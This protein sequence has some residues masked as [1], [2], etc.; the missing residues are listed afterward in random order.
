MK[1]RQA[2]LHERSRDSKCTIARCTSAPGNRNA[3][4]HAAKAF[5][6]MEMRRCTLQKRSRKW[7]CTFAGCIGVS[8]DE[9]VDWKA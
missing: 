4:L 2:L 9:T 6:E 5:P 1:S 3:P 8:W 7:K